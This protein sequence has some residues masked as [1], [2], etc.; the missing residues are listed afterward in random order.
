MNARG[1]CSARF[2]VVLPLVLSIASAASAAPPARVPPPAPTAAAAPA[3][4]SAALRAG[5]LRSQGNQA[6]LDM[7]YSD[8]LTFY[9]QARELAPE[10]VTLLYSIGRTHEFLGEFPQ[11]LDAL[12]LFTAN[13]TPETK[14][15]VG[16]LDDMLKALRTRVSTMTL[17]CDTDGARVLVRNKIVGTTPLAPL[18]LAA[19]AAT[20]QIEFDGFFPD[21]REVVLPGA[22]GLTL[23]IQLH[24]RTSSGVLNVTTE[25]L[26]AHVS[27]DGHDVGTSNPKL[28]LVLPAGEHRVLAQHEGYNDAVMSFV[29][30]PGVSRD[31]AVTMSK[32]VPL[33]SRWWFWTGIGVAV[34]GG[35]VLAAMLL[36]ERHA[37][38]GTLPPGQVGSPLVRF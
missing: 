27:V 16:G 12:E 38:H 22:G 35:T 7:H 8:A 9:A 13:A 6:M 18:R 30:S 20:V 17:K 31:V 33:T 3:E 37:D 29:L 14:T 19:G 10:D 2:P 25:P 36:T 26:G 28:E 23:D 21:K 5:R 24:R 34:V 11:A 1:T 15:K 32:S 4:E